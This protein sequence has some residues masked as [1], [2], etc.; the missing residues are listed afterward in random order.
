MS[1]LFITSYTDATPKDTVKIPYTQYSECSLLA[2]E[3]IHDFIEYI[4][5]E[6]IE[7]ICN[8]S[9]IFFLPEKVYFLSRKDAAILLNQ[10]ISKY[11]V[12]SYEVMGNYTLTIIGIKYDT[13]NKD[14]QTIINILFDVPEGK[15]TAIKVF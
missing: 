5:T 1:F 11:P 3:Q 10:L 2:L 12:Y 7:S 13:Y 14:T 8:D 4:N 15:I 6:N 9:I